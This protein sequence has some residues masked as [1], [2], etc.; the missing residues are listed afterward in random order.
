MPFGELP[1]V[2]RFLKGVL[3]LR[4]V[5]SRCSITWDVSVVLKYIKSI[6]I[7]K[8][9]D[10]KSCSYC[11]A[12][13]LCIRTGQRDQSLF[14]KNI[15]LMMFEA[16]KITVFVPEL[17]KQSHPGHHLEPMVFLRYPDQEICIV[18]H[19]EQYI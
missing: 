18:S 15:E 6:K 14:Y 13:L 2:C 19:L 10:L 7:L 9:C 3:N 5:L 12:I 17:L 16:D 4:P 11:L 1:L 8:Q